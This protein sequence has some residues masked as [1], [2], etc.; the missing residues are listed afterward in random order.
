SSRLTL[1]EGQEL[2]VK[3]TDIYPRTTVCLDALDEVDDKI[4]IRLLKSL[5]WVIEKSNNLVKIFAT[6]RNDIDI[7]YQFKEFPRIDMLSD[8]NFIDI[9]EFIER[10]L[11]SAIDD[12]ELLLGDVSDSLKSEIFEVLCD[13]SKGM[14]QLAALQITFLCQMGTEADVRSSLQ[15]LPDTL[16]EA[17]DEI[18]K[19]IL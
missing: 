12:G 18:Y 6:S 2:L 5:K 16:T 7:L 15:A 3:L 19:R 11:E 10:R 4:R 14:F 13:R 17:Y 9:S 1:Q 8:D